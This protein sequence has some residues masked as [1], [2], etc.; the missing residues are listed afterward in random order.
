MTDPNGGVTT[1]VYDGFGEVIQRV[2]PDSGTTVYRYDPD[3][4]VTQR[5]DAA[6]AIANYTYDALDRVVAI[7]YPADTALNVAY[8]YDQSGYAFGVGRLT[9]LAD[10][11]GTL[12]RSYDERGNVLSETRVIAAVRRLTTYAY[13]AANRVASITYPSGWTAAYSRD[14]MGRV[15]A[16]TVQTPDGGGTIPVLSSI[17]YHPS[18]R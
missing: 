15:T 2:S 7:T 9:T 1:Y 17:G 11:A 8:T 6:G 13:D 18:G 3:G 4:N 16:V 10:A 14:A 12:S 5:V